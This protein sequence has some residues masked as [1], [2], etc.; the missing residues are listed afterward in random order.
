MLNKSFKRIATLLA[1]VMLCGLTA[2]G[3]EETGTLSDN[4]EGLVQSAHQS[5]EVDSENNSV[6]QSSQA[7]PNNSAAS[8]PQSSQAKP[9]NSAA[10]VPQSTQAAPESSAAS[11]PQS[12]VAPENGSLPND[13]SSQDNIP[14][15]FSKVLE[16]DWVHSEGQEISSESEIMTGPLFTVSFSDLNSDGTPEV[17]L[18]QK[19]SNRLPQV[20]DIYVIRDDGISYQCSFSGTVDEQFPIYINRET[21]EKIFV[22]KN[23]VYQ[24]SVESQTTIYCTYF[25]DFTKFECVPLC[26]SHR[27][28]VMSVSR[29][30]TDSAWYCDE[31]ENAKL[32][33]EDEYNKIL[34]DFMEQL[35][36]W[37]NVRFQTSTKLVHDRS[38]FG[39][40]DKEVKDALNDLYSRYVN[41]D[42]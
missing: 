6:P 18:S 5:S 32:I 8:V 29:F 40:S 28:D 38:G 2:C 20:N 34:E 4:T 30:R 13:Q 31:D 26:S 11:T 24:N 25:D 27:D 37:D 3:K 16:Y 21:G 36:L 10:S 12:S 33:T 15:W 14:D 35:E 41:T 39:S 42:V 19:Y 17:I 9:N 22:C 23:T 7:K 1:A